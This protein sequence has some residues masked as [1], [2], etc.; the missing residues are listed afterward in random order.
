MKVEKEQLDIVRE[1]GE[2]HAWK[3]KGSTIFKEGGNQQ[4][5]EVRIGKRPLDFE[6]KGSLLTFLRNV[7]K[8]SCG[9]KL[10]KQKTSIDDSFRD[11]DYKMKKEDEKLV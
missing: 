3:T 8:L 5:Q 4:S 1:Q 7:K 6:I 11:M 9:R 10:R 2:N